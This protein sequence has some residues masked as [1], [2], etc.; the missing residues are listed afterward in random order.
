[1]QDSSC[2]LQ[3]LSTFLAG[4]RPIRGAGVG[5]SMNLAIVVDLSR[6]WSHVI[7]SEFDLNWQVL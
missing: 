7:S 4:V 3:L 5:A 6:V 1:L 2:E